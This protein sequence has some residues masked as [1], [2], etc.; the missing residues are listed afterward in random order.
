MRTGSPLAEADQRL[1]LDAFA[2]RFDAPLARP[3]AAVADELAP[4]PF[5]AEAADAMEDAS[6][7]SPA[8]L[9]RPGRAETL[10]PGPRPMPSSALPLP[11][12]TSAVV[13]PPV[14]ASRRRSDA[15]EPASRFAASPPSPGRA[16]APRS[17][18]SEMP[19][20]VP[21]RPRPRD[22]VAR[23]PDLAPAP[24]PPIDPSRARATPSMTTPTTT[25][26]PRV[27]DA[28]SQAL[29]KVATW[30]DQPTPPALPAPAVAEASAARE[31]E[32]P[33]SVARREPLRA[34]AEP[35]GPS[36]PRLEIGSIEVEVVT[37]QRP[38]RAPAPARTPGPA[39]GSMTPV[40]GWRQR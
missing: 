18:A 21:E 34:S 5:E 22:A 1:H 30:L 16:P 32:A 20:P 15:A 3:A 37:P 13:P 24:L 11:S 26:A 4:D 38:R 17:S 19:A 25:P 14:A 39:A 6:S 31:R 40:F 8:R 35:T 2:A 12:T 29:A 23:E 10:A 27:P 7:R 28:V 9:G 33:S 36:R